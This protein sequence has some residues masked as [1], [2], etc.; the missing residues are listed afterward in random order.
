MPIDSEKVR[1]VKK[2]GLSER[3]AILE[4]ASARKISPASAERT[5][6][7]RKKDPKATAESIKSMRQGDL[8]GSAL[9][10]MKDGVAL[11]VEEQAAFDKYRPKRK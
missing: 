6:Y 9:A 2:R 10:K 5:P 1:E 8:Y 3:D 4:V 7:N 11:S